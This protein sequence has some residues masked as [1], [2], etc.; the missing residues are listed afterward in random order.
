MQHSKCQVLR[1]DEV[2]DQ[3]LRR[4]NPEYEAVDYLYTQAIERLRVER[5]RRLARVGESQLSM[6]GEEER[7]LLESLGKAE[8]LR[9]LRQLLSDLPAGLLSK[10]GGNKI[11]SGKGEKVLIKAALDKSIS[12]NITQLVA[13]INS[14]SSETIKPNDRPELIAKEYLRESINSSLIIQSADY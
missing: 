7:E 8:D 2:A 9:E 10:V 1:A 14:S 11:D 3:V 5:V 12:E 6:L 13:S 4:A